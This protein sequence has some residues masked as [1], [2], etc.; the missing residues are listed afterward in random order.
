MTLTARIALLILWLAAAAASA[1]PV[2][3]C[4]IGPWQTCRYLAASGQP[5]T[6]ALYQRAEPFAEGFGAVQ[7]GGLWGYVDEVGDLVIPARYLQAAPFRHGLAEV[8]TAAG[9]RLLTPS[10]VELTLPVMRRAIP[11]SARAVMAY[12][13]DPSL[14]AQYPDHSTAAELWRLP[15]DEEPY[16]WVKASLYSLT[17]G[18]ISLP[19]MRRW[20]PIAGADHS[21][22]FQIAEVGPGWNL[23]DWGLM[24]DDGTWIIPPG[25]MDIYPLPNG[26]TLTFRLPG[27][28]R[29]GH[30]S[31]LGWEFDQNRLGQK[32]VLDAEGRSL[33]GPFADVGATAEDRAIVQQ[34][35]K[36]FLID[37]RGQL[38]AFDGTPTP[39]YWQPRV[40]RSPE[41]VAHSVSL[42]CP[43][44]LHLFPD[45]QPRDAEDAYALRWGLRDDA[46][47]VVI[48]PD[49]PV[50]SCPL[51]GVAL[52]PDFARRL[53]CPV[54]P[55]PQA[56]NPANCQRFLWDGWIRESWDQKRPRD[57]DP[58]KAQVLTWQ[59]RFLPQAFPALFPVPQAP[60]P[61]VQQPVPN[62]P[63]RHSPRPKPR[64]T[65]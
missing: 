22:W 64:V 41:W 46:G 6:K 14:A 40:W 2:P 42:T 57:P 55:P 20:M 65:F 4:G 63:P 7:I 52:V 62:G 19:P 61:S 3:D 29:T 37:E 12:V 27:G 21:F 31:Y 15:Q 45:R 33:G 10:G 11:V 28:Q 58:F 26:L 50:I 32:A 39:L 49:Y 34:G 44:G 47:Q 51:N 9:T 43:G 24:R 30:D 35:G 23:Y 59:D 56:D 48:T 5:L 54:A 18:W 60:A 17:K 1:Q 13:D 25:I 36:W 8:A 53:W 16:F 38:T